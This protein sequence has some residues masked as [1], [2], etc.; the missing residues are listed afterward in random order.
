MS[1]TTGWQHSNIFAGGKLTATYDTRG[2]HFELAD[3]LGIKRVQANA[4]G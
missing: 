3:P 1:A 2:I 4:L